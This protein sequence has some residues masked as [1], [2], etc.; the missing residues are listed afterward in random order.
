MT[1]AAALIAAAA[2]ALRVTPAL[3]GYFAGEGL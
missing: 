2:L 1:T 3:R